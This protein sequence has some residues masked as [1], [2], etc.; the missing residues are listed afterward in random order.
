MR[1][2]PV[3]ASH[4]STESCWIVPG[5][6]DVESENGITRDVVS[7]AAD[8]LETTQITT[9]AMRNRPFFIDPSLGWPRYALTGGE[10]QPDSVVGRHPGTRWTTVLDHTSRSGVGG[11]GGSGG[12]LPEGPGFFADLRSER[13]KIA[14]EMAKRGTVSTRSNQ[15]GFGTQS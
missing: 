12:V 15:E 10:C 8:R 13:V 11:G 2:P 7:C 14:T 1:F 4:S 9:A 6:S 5:G 3:A